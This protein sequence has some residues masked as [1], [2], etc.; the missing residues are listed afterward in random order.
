MDHRTAWVGRDPMD[1]EVP[2]PSATGRATNPI[3][4]VLDQ[5]V[6]GPIQYLVL[7]TLCFH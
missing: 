1:H 7:N 6:Q 2:T 5:V 3:D 4:L